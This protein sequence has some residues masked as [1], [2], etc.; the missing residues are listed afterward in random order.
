MAT[1]QDI[2]TQD[3]STVDSGATLKEAAT[4]MR[5]Q[6]IGNVLVMDGQ[7][8]RGILTDRDIVVRAVAYGHDLGS[9]VTDYATGNVLTLGADTE[10]GEAARTMSERQVRRVPVTD[11]DRV[12]GIVSLADL[13]VRASPEEGGEALEG[14]SQPTV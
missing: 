2:M 5:E 13:A 3:L 4:L 8:L 10:V 12:V 11:G 1:L 14:I 7:T 9:P 6:D